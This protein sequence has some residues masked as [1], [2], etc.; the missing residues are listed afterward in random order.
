MNRIRAHMFCLAGLTLV[1]ACEKSVRV[2][3]PPPPGDSIVVCGQRLVINSPVYVW[4][5]PGGYNAYAEHCHFTPEVVMP[6]G[7][8]DPSSPR[9]YSS[10]SAPGALA[11][12]VAREGWTLENLQ[13]RVDQ[14]VIHFDAVGTSRGCFRVL[15][16]VRGLSAHFLL[17]L[18]GTL[19]QTLDLKERAWHA[20]SANDQSIGIEIAHIGAYQNMDVLGNWYAIDQQGWPYVIFPVSVG[21]TG[22]RTPEFRARP[23]RQE[24]ITGTINGRSLMQYDFTNEQYEALIRLTAALARTFPRIKLKVPRDAAGQVRRDD[25]TLQELA[26]Y[27]GLIGH[28]HITKGKVDPGPA[29]DWDRVLNGARVLLA[30]Q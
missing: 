15:H 19:Y 6:S 12:K 29:F 27:Q 25:M 30:E 14:F 23:A 3:P 8:A 10:R 20:G 13:Q 21:E 9:R 28:W 2:T 24:L 16:D 11:A 1:T 5:Q 7:P 18:D 22:I 4:D 26:R 17:D